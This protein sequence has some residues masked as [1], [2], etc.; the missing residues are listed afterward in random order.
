[1]INRRDIKLY[2]KLLYKGNVC[3]QIARIEARTQVA[4][5]RRIP[6]LSSSCQWRTLSPPFALCPIDHVRRTAITLFCCSRGLDARLMTR[7]CS[8]KNRAVSGM[9]KSAFRCHRC[10]STRRKTR[11]TSVCG[12]KGAGQEEASLGNYANLVAQIA[13]EKENR[14]ESARRSDVEIWNLAGGQRDR[15][16]WNS[17]CEWCRCFCLSKV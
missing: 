8:A 6:P 2:I 15:R 7:R 14:I 10:F 13:I 11:R 3:A 9:R 12:E 4:M 5:R 1:M 17:C 16:G